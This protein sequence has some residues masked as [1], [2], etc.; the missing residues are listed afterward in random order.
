MKSILIALLVLG[1]TYAFAQKK[2]QT[3]I[4]ENKFYSAVDG[5]EKSLTDIIEENKGKIIYI[6][7]W[8]SWCAPCREVMPE[9]LELIE[10]LANKEIVYF[11][12]SIDNDIDKWTRASRAEGI[13]DYPLSYKILNYEN[14]DFIKQ[15]DL[16]V[17]PRYILIDEEGKI[18]NENAPGPKGD[19]IRKLLIESLK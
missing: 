3:I 5:S 2:M 10:E 17:I 11:Y 4:E 12:I 14:A 7:F 6:D 9:S 8:A 15:I 16:K 1:S 19:Q 13:Y 18:I